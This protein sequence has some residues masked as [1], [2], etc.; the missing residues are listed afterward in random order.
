V[1][2][3][4]QQEYDDGASSDTASIWG[5][6]R[7]RVESFAQRLMQPHPV[8]ALRAGELDAVCVAR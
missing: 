7:R 1:F 3:S 8:G 2:A 4:S 6:L 5:F